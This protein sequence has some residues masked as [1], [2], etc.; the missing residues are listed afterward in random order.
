MPPATVERKVDFEPTD[1]VAGPA[2]LLWKRNV[3]LF[4]NDK[5]DDRGF[6]TS[7]TLM[8]LDEGA[9]LGPAWAAANNLNIGGVGAVAAPGAQAIA[10]GA[11]M[12]AHLRHRKARLKKASAFIVKHVSDETTLF[13]FADVN[14]GFKNDGRRCTTTSCRRSSH[15]SSPRWW[16]AWRSSGS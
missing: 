3:L 5:P 7:D 14:G 2:G 16:R 15:P 12:Q 4:S 8:R 9:V 1:T 13:L 6:T 10:A 11:H